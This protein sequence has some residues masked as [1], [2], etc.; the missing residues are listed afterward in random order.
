M[1]D[2]DMDDLDAEP[3]VEGQVFAGVLKAGVVLLLLAAGLFWLLA[4]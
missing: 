3:S 4:G 2:F 1:N